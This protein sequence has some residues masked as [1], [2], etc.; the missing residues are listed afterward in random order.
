MSY[1][2]DRKGSVVEHYD[3]DAFRRKSVRE[4]TNND[5]GE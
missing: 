1:E 3:D 5:S 4:L 2:N